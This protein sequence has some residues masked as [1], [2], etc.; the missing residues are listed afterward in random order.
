MKCML[1]AKTAVLLKLNLPPHGFYV[2]ARVVINPLASG[3]FELDE[4][5]REF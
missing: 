3:A 2:L 1:T 4:V 5:F